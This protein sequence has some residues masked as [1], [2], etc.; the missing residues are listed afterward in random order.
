MFSIETF[1]TIGYGAPED[2]IFF[3]QCESV[4]VVITLQCLVHLLV[5]AVTIG[6]IYCRLARPSSRASTIIFSDK[7]VI[8][9]I[10]GRLY[11]MFQ[12]WELRKHQLVEAHIRLYEIKHKFNDAI[13]SSK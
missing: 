12:L 9:R 5:E 13:K 6:V 1:A 11:F 4:T 3:G 7:A 8:R 10:R 2:D